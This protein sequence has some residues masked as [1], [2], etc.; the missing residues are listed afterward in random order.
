MTEVDGAWLHAWRRRGERFAMHLLV[1]YTGKR[2][3]GG[4]RRARWALRGK[5]LLAW[6]GPVRLFG[7]MAFAELETHYAVSDVARHLFLS[8]GEAAYERLRCAEKRARTQGHPWL[9]EL[10]IAN[11]LAAV[12]GRQGD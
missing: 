2:R 6:A 1:A 7:P 8:D 3:G 9:T 12:N 11:L 4:G 5:R 10:Q